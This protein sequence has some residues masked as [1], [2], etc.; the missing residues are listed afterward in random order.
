M[1][2]RRNSIANAM[3]LR[4]SCTNPPICDV[5]RQ[6]RIQFL[7]YKFVLAW[8]FFLALRNFCQYFTGGREGVNFI[9]WYT[10]QI[11]ASARESLSSLVCR[12]RWPAIL[13]IT[14]VCYFGYFPENSWKFDIFLEILLQYFQIYWVQKMLRDNSDH[15]LTGG[16]W[17]WWYLISIHFVNCKIYEFDKIYEEC[18]YIYTF[19]L[20]IFLREM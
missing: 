19:D 6:H 20:W 3:E 15:F 8:A 12:H 2:K 11:L 4:L 18:I 10:S 7:D 13:P 16:K 1:Q 5:L 17:W 9:H 14:T